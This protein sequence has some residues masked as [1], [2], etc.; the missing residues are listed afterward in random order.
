MEPFSKRAWDL[1]CIN[2]PKTRF[3]DVPEGMWPKLEGGVEEQQR[4]GNKSKLTNKMV[5]NP[6]SNKNHT[7]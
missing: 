4:G 7:S 2:S 5:K 3:D 1:S 6:L